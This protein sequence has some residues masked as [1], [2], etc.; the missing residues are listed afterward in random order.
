MSCVAPAMGEEIKMRLITS[1]IC[2][3]LSEQGSKLCVCVQSGGKD[4]C[5][6]KV[7]CVQRQRDEDHDQTTGSWYGATDADGV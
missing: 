1:E 6:A 5:S 2:V 4:G 3:S 7:Y